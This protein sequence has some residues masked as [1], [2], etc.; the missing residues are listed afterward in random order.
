M[1][2]LLLRRWCVNIQVCRCVVGYVA[3]FRTIVVPTGPGS[4]TPRIALSRSK[5]ITINRN[6][7]KYLKSSLTCQKTPNL[8]VSFYWQFTHQCGRML[9][10]WKWFISFYESVESVIRDIIHRFLKAIFLLAVPVHTGNKVILRSQIVAVESPHW[11]RLMMW[12]NASLFSWS[13]SFIQ[14]SEFHKE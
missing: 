3:T 7:E 6:V 8:E 1:L 9:C 5:V 2:T 12:T 11:K 14:V 4:S 13:G 10:V